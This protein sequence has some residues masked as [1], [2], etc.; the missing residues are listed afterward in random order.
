[1]T[2]KAAT[3]EALG[4]LHGRV[5]KVMANA[6]DVVEKAQEVYLELPKEDAIGPVPE[7]SASLLSVITKFL[8]D[9]KISA[10]AGDSK[11]VSE[12]ATLLSNKRRRVG[13]VVHIT[14]DE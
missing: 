14:N 7:V 2:T 1:M 11:N 12:L 4:E 9:N 10:D 3:E 5:A 8:V 13:N 6:L